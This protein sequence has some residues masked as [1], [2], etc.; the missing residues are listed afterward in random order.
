[1]YEK[2]LNEDDGEELLFIA[3][4]RGMRHIMA[5]LDEINTRMKEEVITVPLDK[6]PQAAAFQ[7]Y[8]K[9][10]MALGAESARN[11]FKNRLSDVLLKREN[12][13]L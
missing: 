11:A 1:M 12:K 5:I 6:D 7:V 8:A 2:R 10:M 3:G 9:R 4:H 13:K